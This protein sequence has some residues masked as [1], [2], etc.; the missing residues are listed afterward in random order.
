MQPFLDSA[1][2]LIQGNQYVFLG[3][4]IALVFLAGFILKQVKAL[5]VV[6]VLLASAML[7]FIVYKGSVD[8]KKISEMKKQVKGKLIE[9]PKDVK[10]KR[11]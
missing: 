6:L 2:K 9:A 10:K 3:V 11:Q 8:T 7:Y 4:C 1:V 5:A